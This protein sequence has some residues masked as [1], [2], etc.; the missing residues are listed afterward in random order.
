[1]KKTTKIH[2]A[3]ALLLLP[4]TTLAESFTYNLTYDGA[5]RVTHVKVDEHNTA[6]YEYRPNG[7]L[8]RVTLTGKEQSEPSGTLQF[9]ASNYS[10]A[11]NKDS[12]T[13][14]VTRTNGSAG[15][16]SV[17]YATSDDTA[18]ADS[19]YTPATGT[20]SWANAD[21]ADKPITINILNDSELEEDETLI[22]SLGNVTG[23]AI[24]GVPDTSILTIKDNDPNE[25]LNTMHNLSAKS[26][27]TS[28]LDNDGQ[29]EIIID[30]GE[31][32]GIWLWMNNNWVQISNLSPDTLVTGDID[33]NGQDEIILDFGTGIELWKN[34]KAWVQLH[35]LSPESMVTGDIDGNGQDELIID[36][37]ADIGIWQWT[38]NSTWEQLHNLSPESMMTRDTDNNGQDEI[39]IDFGADVG[40]WQW[41]NNSTWEQLHSLSPEN[42]VTGNILSH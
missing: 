19:D 42:L 17:D 10:V 30:F 35:P 41:T 21:L 15:P 33:G 4:T 23:G 12:I 27:N 24:L 38:N 11:K 1:M 26:M 25:H 29:N 8:M 18:T 31:P 14:T 36:F 16:V 39:I 5:N 37:G 9:S 7:Q 13:I 40:I 6:D 3:I 2:I 32:N 34:N 22:L 20:L 28:D